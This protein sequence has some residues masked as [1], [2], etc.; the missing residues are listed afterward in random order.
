MSTREGK[1]SRPNLT[2]MEAFKCRVTHWAGRL[3]AQ[4]RQVVV[5]RMTR[6][7]ASCSSSGR[8]CFARELLELRVPD[9]DFVIVHELLHLRHPNHGRV[10]RSLL[11][12]YVPGWRKRNDGLRTSRRALPSNASLMSVKR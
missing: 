7:W 9:Q 3:G 1:R 4:P 12:A 5:M 11:S 6:K 8:V 2:P 10:F